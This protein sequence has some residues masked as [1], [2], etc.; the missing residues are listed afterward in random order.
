MDNKKLA[1]CAVFDNEARYLP[2][3][4]AYHRLVGV[5]EFVLYR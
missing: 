3:W 2:E 4:L 1:V 5:A